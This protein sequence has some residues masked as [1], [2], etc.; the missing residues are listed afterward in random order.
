M[1]III[2]LLAFMV[3]ENMEEFYTFAEVREHLFSFS[4]LLRLAAFLMALF[5]V[6]NIFML[7][8]RKVVSLFIIKNFFENFA[9]FILV[10]FIYSPTENRI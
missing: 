2:Y 3:G 7:P 10:H 8:K 4:M 9:E 1:L 5:Y 6:F